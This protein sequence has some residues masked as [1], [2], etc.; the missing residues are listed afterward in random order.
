[1]LRTA[2]SRLYWGQRMGTSPP[3][4]CQALDCA[5]RVAITSWG[6]SLP[7]RYSCADVL[8]PGLARAARKSAWH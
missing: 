5:T 4:G 7:R 6:R 8:A 3:P 2:A 1:M